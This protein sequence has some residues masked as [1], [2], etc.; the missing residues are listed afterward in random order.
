MAS[1]SAADIFLFVVAFFLPPLVSCSV[2]LKQGC[3]ADFL[4]SIGLTLLGHIPG[5]AYAWYIIYKNRD[6][7]QTARYYGRTYASIPEQ[8]NHH[9]HHVHHSHH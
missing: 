1:F 4:I 7:P 3:G 8:H 5:I 6:D 9:S 2:G